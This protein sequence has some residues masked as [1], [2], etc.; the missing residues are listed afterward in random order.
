[1][2]YLA[3]ITQSGFGLFPKPENFF[4][5]KKL[6]HETFDNLG[7]AKKALREKV[8]ELYDKYELCRE[9]KVFDR[10]A[11]TEVHIETKIGNYDGWNTQYVAEIEKYTDEE[12]EELKNEG[13]V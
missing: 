4:G 3:E 10:M 1:M 11:F 13:L 6:Y 7:D 8:R 5:E 12:Y 2:K 9:W